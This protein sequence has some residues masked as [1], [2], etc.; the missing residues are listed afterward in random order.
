MLIE[1][2]KFAERVIVQIA[3]ALSAHKK[4]DRSKKTI[5]SVLGFQ[6][7]A[8]STLTIPPRSSYT[9]GR[10]VTRVTSSLECRIPEENHAPE[11]TLILQKHQVH[12]Y[13]STTT[14]DALSMLR[15]L[16]HLE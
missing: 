13:A 1:Q 10:A 12:L 7:L 5:A 6:Q 11:K 2:K 16:S 14:Q 15:D 9:P 4:C 3:V 8:L